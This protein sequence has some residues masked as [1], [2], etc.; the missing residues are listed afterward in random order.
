MLLVAYD[1]VWR[2]LRAGKGMLCLQEVKYP[3]QQIA[4]YGYDTKQSLHSN[5]KLVI[6][7]VFL[8]PEFVINMVN[9][10]IT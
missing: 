10:A 1:G 8:N 6:L 4:E 3:W 7:K 9:W 2:S 5:S